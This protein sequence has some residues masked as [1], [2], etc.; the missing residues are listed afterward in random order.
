MRQTLLYINGTAPSQS[1]L[2]ATMGTDTTIQ[3][4]TDTQ[5]FRTVNSLQNEHAYY[6]IDI[7]SE[8]VFQNSV[9]ASLSSYKPVIDIVNT[10]AVSEEIFSYDAKHFLN[11]SGIESGGGQMFI[12]DPAVEHTA[13]SLEELENSRA[14]RWVSTDD[15]YTVTTAHECSAIIG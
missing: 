4:T 10:A 8:T 1:S 15:M 2:A 5:M 11:I 3:G 9:Y 13:G 6:I 12:V 7:T 14:K